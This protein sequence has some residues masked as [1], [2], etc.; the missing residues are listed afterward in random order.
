MP[1]CS[2][3]RRGRPG[4]RRRVGASERRRERPRRPQAD[5]TELDRGR[6]R[7]QGRNGKKV[8]K[9]AAAEPEK[10]ENGVTWYPIRCLQ[11]HHGANPGNVWKWGRDNPQYVRN[12]K[13][14]GRGRRG[15]RML[16][17]HEKVLQW[18]GWQG[19]SSPTVALNGANRGDQPPTVNGQ[20][21]ADQRP[22]HPEAPLPPVPVKK[23]TSPADGP[24]PPDGLRISGT[25]YDEFSASE[26]HLLVCLWGKPT[27]KV[28]DV[29]EAVY[30]DVDGKD[31]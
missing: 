24:F 13:H 23:N 27:V 1:P 28:Q 17:Y 3:E 18:L 26:F 20:G 21:E 10:D 25:P 19:G 7:W 12:P 2:L 22:P 29:L 6:M 31:V 30:G 5:A 15:G 9:D 16:E 11:D 8:V 14:A 4:R